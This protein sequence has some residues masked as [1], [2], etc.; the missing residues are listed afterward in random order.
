MKVKEF[1]K[2]YLIWIILIIGLIGSIIV[3]VV[4]INDN[5]LKND[6]VFEQNK[7][8]N[9]IDKTDNDTINDNQED[10]DNEQNNEVNSDNL[11][12][13]NSSSNQESSN[14][15][16]SNDKELNDNKNNSNVNNNSNNGSSLNN[17]NDSNTNKNNSD[18]NNN[19]NK[20]NSSNTNNNSKNDDN[21]NNNSTSNNSSNTNNNN[22]NSNNKQEETVLTQAE[23]NNQYRN[24]IQDT[25]SIKIAYGNEMGDYLIGYYAPTKLTDDKQIN[26][27]LKR[28]ET[29]MKK[30]PKGFFKEMKDFGMPLTIYVVKDIPNSGISGLTDSQ[31]A[32]NV[33]I[34]V[35]TNL[36]FENTLNHEIMHYIDTYISMKMYPDEIST[37]W[38]K[39]NPSGYEY[40]SFDTSLD[41]MTTQDNNAYFLSN[42]AQTNWLEDRATLFGDAM[43]MT[44]KRSCYTVGTPLYNKMKLI[45]EQIDKYYTSVNGT[46]TQYWE[47][48]L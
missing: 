23:I 29:E 7:V 1:I 4:L 30:Y 39:L 34:S 41:F 48:F 35:K 44:S 47:R 9:I 13:D 11:N 33:I 24:T 37:S 28:I 43:T 8:N 27:Y 36:F 38:N 15:N 31:F 25:Y 10:K 42:Y 46:G 21:K 32:S 19:S 26:E 14:N 18:T 2:K 12:D 17:K 40:G 6:E 5:D 22:N 45:S 3:G 20:D 16:E